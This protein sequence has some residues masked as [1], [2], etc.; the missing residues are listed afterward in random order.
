MKLVRMSGRGAKEAA[1][2]LGEVELRHAAGAAHVES[3]VRRIV[4]GVRKGGDVALR[5]YAEK[6]DG[7]SKQSQIRIDPAEMKTAWD[8][9]G[10]DLRAAITSAARN[11]RKFAER[12]L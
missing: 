3:A 5:R 10:A 2:L 8:E 9:T 1:K 4:A 6:L 7:I 12:Q 11:I